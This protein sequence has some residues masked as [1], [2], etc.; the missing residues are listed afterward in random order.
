MSLSALLMLNSFAFSAGS[1]APL[2]RQNPR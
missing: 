1:L 2:V